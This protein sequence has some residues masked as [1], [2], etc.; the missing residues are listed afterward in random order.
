M[1]QSVLSKALQVVFHWTVC[2]VHRRL[3]HPGV[4]S[5]I[6]GSSSVLLFQTVEILPRVTH[7]ERTGR[8]APE[9]IHGKIQE[10]SFKYVQLLMY[11]CM[12]HQMFDTDIQSSQHKLAT[13]RACFAALFYF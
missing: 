13:Q 6:D 5:A 2:P 8:F 12:I 11:E 10:S 1:G 3:R 7:P 4:V 9:F